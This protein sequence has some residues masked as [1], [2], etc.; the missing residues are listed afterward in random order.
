MGLKDLFIKFNLGMFGLDFNT[1][2]N[3]LKT[4]GY[5]DSK[6][7]FEIDLEQALDE[8]SIVCVRINDINKF[9]L[10]QYVK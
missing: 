9:Y 2:Y 6:E 5:Y 10:K 8:G 4:Q 3:V 1:I 7:R